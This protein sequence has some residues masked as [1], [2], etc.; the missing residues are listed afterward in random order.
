VIH[1]DKDHIEKVTNNF[2]KGTDC[3]ITKIKERVK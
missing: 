2:G 3:D 1:I